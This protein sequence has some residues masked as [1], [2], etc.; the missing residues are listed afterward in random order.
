MRK[1]VKYILG[2]ALAIIVGYNSVNFRPLDEKL[3]ENNDTVFDADAFVNEIWDGGIFVVFDSAVEFSSLLQQLRS[4]PQSAFNQH[5]NSLAIGNIGFFRVKGEGIVQQVKP[6]NVLMNIGDQL[7][8]IETEFIFGNAVRD[9]SGLVKVSDFDKTSDLNSISESIN[10]KI[11]EDIIPTFR[12]EVKVG[13]KVT[14]MGAMELNKAHLD[15]RLPK[16]I[17]VAIKILQ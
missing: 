13:N 2:S 10:D 1:G 6:N 16:I 9:A 11:R 4:D 5:A 12:S 14:F 8:E 3:S 15:L 7:V 17:P